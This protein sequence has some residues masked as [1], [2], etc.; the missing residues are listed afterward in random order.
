MRESMLDPTYLVLFFVAIAFAPYLV[1]I[2]R[3][4]AQA[5]KI[6]FRPAP[7]RTLARE[8]I[9]RAVIRGH[10]L[11]ITTAVLY[12]GVPIIVNALGP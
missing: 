1:E 5:V 6:L 11:S 7:G 2:V 3:L 12:I 10:A 4:G 9:R 8:E